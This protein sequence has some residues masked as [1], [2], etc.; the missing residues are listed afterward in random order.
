MSIYMSDDLKNIVNQDDI[1][2]VVEELDNIDYNVFL[3]IH[4][5]YFKISDIDFIENKISLTVDEEYLSRL[6]NSVQ[7]Q[8]CYDIYIKKQL[9]TRVDEPNL[10]LLS[11]K[12]KDTQGI[13][14]VIKE[15]SRSFIW[16]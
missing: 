13:I 12:D 7:S 5:L 2:E 10:D 11:I 8:N 14:V 15:N 3:K 4:S 1:S 6:I 16:K 9:L